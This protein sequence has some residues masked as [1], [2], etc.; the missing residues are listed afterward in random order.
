[1]SLASIV[2]D[3]M[4]VYRRKAEDDDEHEDDEIEVP[5]AS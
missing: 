2:I 4:R 1:M 3:L 5:L